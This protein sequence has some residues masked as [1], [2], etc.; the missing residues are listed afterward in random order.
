MNPHDKAYA[1]PERHRKE[2]AIY[3]KNALDLRASAQRVMKELPQKMERWGKFR[4]IS[5]KEV[6]RSQWANEKVSA[7]G[8]R[9]NSFVRVRENSHINAN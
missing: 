4:V 3:F 8:R 1:L 5:E 9:D 6:V 7:D 2:V